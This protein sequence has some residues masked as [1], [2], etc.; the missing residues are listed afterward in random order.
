MRR[1]TLLSAVLAL[2]LAVPAAAADCGNDAAGF[3]AWLEA[4][5]SEAVARGIDARVAATALDGITYNK[6][7]IRL[8][9][10]QKGTFKVPFETFAAKRVTKS[11]ISQGK[12]MLQ[13]HADLLASIE[14]RYGVQPEVI[15]A[16]WGMETD[17][18]VVRGKMSV[19]RSLATLAYDCRRSEFFTNELLSA[20]TI[21]QRGDKAPSDLVGAWAGEIGQ[22]QF[23][24][25]NYL[26]YAV[27]A[28]GNGRRDLI[29]STP[30]VLAS[31]A[32][33]L[34]AH[35]WSAGGDYNPGGANFAVLSGWNKSTNYQKAIALFASKLLQ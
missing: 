12:K 15:V 8:D 6:E 28:D 5:K 35:G 21:I 4:F 33:L 1:T 7:V 29:R 13:K 31:T 30:D 10:G 22:T 26:R 32:N 11:R 17:F 20:L 2:S 14:R 34:A 27:D 18:G 16:I 25:S 24:A 9:R 23:L 3:P 19:V